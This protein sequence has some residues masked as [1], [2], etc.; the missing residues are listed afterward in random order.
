MVTASDW[1][2]EVHSFKSI[3][4]YF[5]SLSHAGDMLNISFFCGNCND[6][7]ELNEIMTDTVTDDLEE[8]CPKIEHVKKK[9]WKDGKLQNLGKRLK[10]LKD[11]QEARNK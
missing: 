11:P 2:T 10:T 9:P 7:D 6:M 3:R 5:F 8:V 1:C 4:D